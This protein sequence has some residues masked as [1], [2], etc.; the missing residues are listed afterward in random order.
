MLR[1]GTKTISE[2]LKS[3]I[4]YRSKSDTLKDWYIWDLDLL[5]GNIANDNSFIFYFFCWLKENKF[6]EGDSI[7]KVEF[8][9]I[10]R[11]HNYDGT[12]ILTIALRVND[13]IW[14]FKYV[15]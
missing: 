10:K 6:N 3:G 7:F 1:F 2:I 11:E 12:P 15:Y 14:K 4:I 9:L 5:K 8:K 13:K